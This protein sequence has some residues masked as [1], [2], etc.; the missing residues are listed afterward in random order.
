MNNDKEP[1]AKDLVWACLTCGAP[2]GPHDCAQAKEP[3]TDEQIVNT[4]S[5][6]KGEWGALPAG[7]GFITA[8]SIIQSLQAKVAEQERAIKRV[9]N[10]NIIVSSELA[11]AEAKIAR[12]EEVCGRVFVHSDDP[13][14]WRVVVEKLRAALAD[15]EETK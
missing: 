10:A 15:T 11:E 13:T 6:L 5:W 1:I 4:L 8:I 3:I 12:I 2:Y 14:Y 9:R 7:T